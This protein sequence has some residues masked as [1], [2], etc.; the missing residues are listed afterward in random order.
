MARLACFGTIL[1]AFVAAGCQNTTPTH[2]AAALPGPNFAGP[3]IVQVA[4]PPPVAPKPQQ[5]AK[6]PPAKPGNVPAAWI[7]VKGAEQREWTWIVIHHSGGAIGGAKSFDKYHR[8]VKGWDELGYHFVIG[9]GSESGDG[10]IEVGPRWPVQKHGAHAKTVD[11][12]YNEHGIGICLVGNFD[13]TRPTPKQMASLTKLV[14]YLADTYHVTQPNI[15]G[16]KMTGKSTDCPGTNMDIAQV[17]AAVSRQRLAEGDEPVTT[18]E[19]AQREDVE[20]IQSASA[21]KAPDETN[22]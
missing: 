15:I 12:K 2:T 5:I 19:T 1:A 11:N 7:P 16:H 13:Q 4:P 10:E 3:S 17:R 8:E 22:R 6:A 14:A 18:E 9:N 20:L 21:A